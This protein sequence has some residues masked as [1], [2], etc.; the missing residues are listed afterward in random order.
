M[1]IL[2]KAVYS[3]KLEKRMLWVYFVKILGLQTTAYLKQN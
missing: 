3:K 1:Y 2:C